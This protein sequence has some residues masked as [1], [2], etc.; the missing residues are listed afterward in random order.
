[1]S[2]SP[3]TAM[4][5]PL[6]VSFFKNFPYLLTCLFIFGCSGPSL[7]RSGFLQWRQVEAT[8]QWRGTG[9]SL[10]GF[11]LFQST[12]CRATRAS[13][14]AVHAYTL[15]STGSVA[16]APAPAAAHGVWRLPGRGAGSAPPA[17]AG[18]F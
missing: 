1:M 18:G 8:L 2:E 12:G 7:L 10:Q 13:V 17:L 9:V 15:W 5:V 6:L 3:P 11:L 4:V 16:G 14:A